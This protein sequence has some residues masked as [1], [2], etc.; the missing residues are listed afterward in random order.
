[1]QPFLTTKNSANIWEEFYPFPCPFQSNANKISLLIYLHSINPNIK[2]HLHVLRDIIDQP[3]SA[4]VYDSRLRKALRVKQKR[5]FLWCHKPYD[6]THNVQQRTHPFTNT[7]VPTHSF[8]SS[9]P[10]YA[11]HDVTKILFHLSHSRVN[12]LKRA[13]RPNAFCHLLN[14]RS[15]RYSIA[16]IPQLLANL[17]RELFDPEWKIFVVKNIHGKRVIFNLHS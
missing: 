7:T 15:L 1:M 4:F 6:S 2:H 8:T 10:R 5:I 3:R 9:S 14:I 11:P 16:D 17:F 12:F 13:R